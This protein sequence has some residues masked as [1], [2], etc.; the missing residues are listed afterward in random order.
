MA[1]AESAGAIYYTVDAQT[2]KLLDSTEQVEAALDKTSKAFA[3]TDKAAA[4]TQAQM[5][6][7]AA[8]TKE[9]VRQVEAAQ[10]PLGNL[11]KLLGGL[12]T[13]QGASAL[14]QMA[15]S[16]GAMAE[17]VQMATK[18]QEEY[19]LVQQRLLATS[20]GTYRALSESQEIFI[21]TSENLR[22]LGYTLEQALDVTD[23][24]SYSFVANATA[25]DRAQNALRA[26]DMALNKGKLEADGWITVIGAIP[27]I[28]ADIA[29]ATG[30]TAQ[31]IRELGA[32]GK[33]TA[34][35]L[36]EGLRTSLEKNK[37]AADGMAVSIKDAFVATRNNIAAYVGEANRASGSTETMAKA[38]MLL[39][40]NVETVANALL[41]LGAGA[42]A[43]YLV[44]LT[45]ATLASGRAAVAARAQAAEN[46][47]VA[48]ANLAAA[49]AAEAHAAANVGLI[50]GLTSQ[51]SAARATAAAQAQ[52]ATAQTAARAA[53]AGLMGILGGP[54]GIVAL[55]ATA[56]VGIY[57][58]GSKSE[59]AAPKVDQLTESID[60]LTAAQLEQRKMQ[61][62]SAVE[63]LT[64]EAISTADAGSHIREWCRKGLGERFCS[65]ERAVQERQG[66]DHRRRH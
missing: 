39:G 12:V 48:Q 53:G 22:D 40:N 28:A 24:L 47:R 13:L 16:Y 38:I 57:A 14:I 56:A 17:R 64:Q 50:A 4:A 26:Y 34:A 66:R 60:K 35:M 61:A 46:L 27:T 62:A 29:A 31:E 44:T 42:M 15:E 63:K 52:L 1:T 30:K 37:A 9:M 45:A 25:T 7:T 3:K 43:K 41:A 8:A 2:G 6:Q 51:A 5:T 55:L 49:A 10:N 11:S 21:A 18:T 54:A 33:L 59:Q 23:S 65:P 19:E 36:N 58:F 20:N 32:S